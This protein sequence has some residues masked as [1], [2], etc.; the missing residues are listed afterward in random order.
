[1]KENIVEVMKKPASEL[2]LVILGTSVVTFG[3]EKSLVG[4]VEQP[5]GREEVTLEVVL[6]KIFLKWKP[7]QGTRIHSIQKRI[8]K[9]HVQ[10]SGHSLLG[11]GGP[12]EGRRTGTLLLA[13]PLI[14]KLR[15]QI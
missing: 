10:S 3:A 2:I 14:L 11:F 12:L 4:R 8:Q 5:M 15:Y 6:G 7:L 9:E 13:T 1:M